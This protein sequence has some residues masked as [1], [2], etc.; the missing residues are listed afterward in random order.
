MAAGESKPGHRIKNNLSV[1]TGGKVFAPNIQSDHSSG[2]M[3]ISMGN[4][5]I[6]NHYGG[7]YE[8]K[9]SGADL[10]N[11]KAIHKSKSREAV[12]YMIDYEKK[13]KKRVLLHE[14]FIN[15]RITEGDSSEGE[16][17]EE[18]VI[19][20]G[21]IFSPVPAQS[22]EP[23]TVVTKGLA[24][25]GKSVLVQK[26]IYDW[27]TG[28]ALSEYDFIFKFPFRELSLLSA[29]KKEIS[30]PDLVKQYYPCIKRPASILANESIRT[31]FIFDG[32]SDGDLEVDFNKHIVYREVSGA[33]ALGALLVNL[34]KKE[35]IPKAS[36]WITTRP[37]AKNGIPTEYISRETTIKGF[38]DQ[39]K[40]DYFLRRCKDKALGRKMSQVVKKQRNLFFMCSVP[41]FCSILFSVLET[42]LKSV[43]AEN[44]IPQTLTEVYS[45][46]LV[47]LILF[48]EEKL[49][50][51]NKN[52]QVMSLQSKRDSILA[53]GKLSF[54][55][56]H[57][58][59]C[60]TV[61][62]SEEELKQNNIQLSL[63]CSGL[64]EEAKGD[65]SNYSFV[66]LALQEYFAALYVFLA[67]YNQ[68]K[69]AFGRSFKLFEK[70]GYSQI[71]KE[72]CDSAIKGG[73]RRQEFFLRF[74]C[75][76]GTTKSQEILEGLLASDGKNKERDDSKKIAKF[77]KKT[78]QANIPPEQTIDI[79]H[80]LNELND[81]SAL[82]EIKAAFNSG[83][84]SSGTLSPAQ[85]S[86]LAFVLQMS[87]E[88]YQELDLSLYKLPTIGIRRLLLTANSF[89]GI[90]LSGANIRDSGLK[91][92]TDVMRSPDCKL[93]N[94]KLDGN[95]LTYKSC[96][97]LVAA[98]RENHNV[99]LLDLND[100]NIQDKGVSLLCNALK[101]EQCSLRMLS[102][103]GNKLT[104][105]CCK[106][107]ADMLSENKTLLELDLSHNRIGE[108]GLQDLFKALKNGN[109]KLQKLGLNSI[110]AFEFGIM[111]TYEDASG[112]GIIC[113]ILESQNCK[114]QSLGLAKNSFT[115]VGC[116]KLI[117]SLKGNQTLTELDIG[118]NNLQ[119]DGMTELCDILTEPGCKMQSLKVTN[120]KLTSECCVKLASVFNIKTLTELDVSMNE[121]GNDGVTEL[122]SSLKDSQ[123]QL[124]RLGLSKTGLTDAWS[125]DLKAT[126]AKS[127]QLV[128]L[129]LSHNKFTD[130]SVQRFSDFIVG[131]AKLK[132]IRME[133]NRF[134]AK[135]YKT[136]EDLKMKKDDL[137]K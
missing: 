52:Q 3:T 117:K 22:R 60:E 30:L 15:V 17:T 113:D 125:I 46:F 106:D 50:F 65:N 79:L 2:P 64:C 90:K 33:M 44:E 133:K 71:C 137:H 40:E 58:K 99:I 107:L 82:E 96:E 73:K 12:E 119:N 135:G 32:L 92:L 114:L 42:V 115:Q 95:N 23:V 130:K 1:S 132:T 49:E 129:D 120:A 53:L 19:E 122:L 56:G 48:R 134:S 112:A 84:F 28:T 43:S 136:L 108:S 88:S 5:T 66:H 80:C 11:L 51:V 39:E 68:N 13:G 128:E 27:A 97:Q 78:L 16:K 54:E 69:N 20:Y 14:R 105:S 41:A 18:R 4:K 37:G 116:A 8:K 25:I 83:S 24:G 35:L 101:H 10:K 98:L 67:F 7:A 63:V 85:C 131:C 93:Q 77:L 61:S 127:N 59:D 47:H 109:W 6:V 91:I 104:S 126:F 9:L 29:E 76:L 34:I 62:F 87:E 111:G 70:Q 38:Q 100:N 74:L 45:H 72:A 75:G 21:K 124:Q 26:L 86:A 123:C 110:F 81:I 55:R 57:L 118:S 89:T 31:L 94:V 36:I 103:G 102:V 121:L